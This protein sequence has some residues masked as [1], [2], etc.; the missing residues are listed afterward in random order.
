MDD[1]EVLAA[2][3]PEEAGSDPLAGA[4]RLAVEKAVAV[5]AVRP[6]AV[7]IGSD[8][9]VFDGHQSYG[10]PADANEAVTML[11]A[12]RGR[13][14][15]VATGVAVATA[16]DVRSGCSVATVTM[17]ALASE[18]VERYVASGRPLDKAG[19]YAIQDEDVPTVAALDGCYCCVMG[20]PLWR[21]W[22]ML[23]EAGIPARRPHE[24]IPRCATCPERPG[25]A[26][27]G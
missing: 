6:G 16:G 11:L 1:F 10:K 9:V 3:I 13:S 2:D 18:T 27:G 4:E 19:A 23:Q 17:A 12:L 14:H 22:A 5:L 26:G 24:R 7:V 21:L 15:R 8:T 25:A 20:L